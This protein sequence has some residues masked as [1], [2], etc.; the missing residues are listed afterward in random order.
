MTIEVTQEN[1]IKRLG[2]G[3][4][5]I[6]TDA[7]VEAYYG[8]RFPGMD[9]F[10]IAPGE[11][12]KS[13]ETYER[14][15]AYMQEK[16]MTRGDY[17]IALGGGVVGDL[18]GFAASTYMRG[19]PYINIPTT[20]LAMVD[21]SVGGKTGINMG[22]A[23]NAIGSFYNPTDIWLDVG[24]LETL[25]KRE[26]ASGMAEIIKY[27]IGFDPEMIQQIQAMD[28]PF[29]E[30]KNNREHI[31]ALIIKS[32]AIKEKV[33][34]D[35]FRDSGNRQKLNFGHTLGHAI[36]AYYGFKT[37]THGEAVAI[38]MAYQLKQANQLGRLSDSAYETCMAL[39]N[40]FNLPVD[41]RVPDHICGVAWHVAK[42]KK[43]KAT[44]IH[45]IQL[46]K[47]GQLQ[48]IPVDFTVFIDNL[49]CDLKIKTATVA[50][51]KLSGYI[52]G[53]PS[54]SI[55]HRA[56]IAAGLSET[57]TLVGPLVMSN[58]MMA[59][60]EGMKA[61]GSEIV[62]SK[63]GY[64][65]IHKKSGDV[66]NALI[67]CRES[68]STLRFLMP[69]CFLAKGGVTF[70]GEGR[71]GDRPLTPYYKVFDE[72]EVA[73]TTADGGL[74]V[75]VEGNLKPGLYE[76]PGNISSQFVTGLLMALPLLDG[77]SII[78]LTTP[79]ESKGYVDLTLEVLD[80]YNVKIFQDSELT[81]RIPGNQH[82]EGQ[83]FYVESDYSQAAF[84][85][86]A[87][88]LGSNVKVEGLNEKSRQGDRV[89]D[90][91]L[92]SFACKE[93]TIDL[94]NCPDLLPILSVVAAVT[95]GKTTF[96]GGKRVRLKESDRL[97][98][99]AVELDKMGASIEETPDGLVI[100][101]QLTLK[102]GHVWSWNDHRVAMALAIAAT[103]C[104]TEVVIHG[105]QS[106]DKS[107]PNFWE[108]Y[109]VLGGEVNVQHIG[110]TV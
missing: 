17:L 7:N 45:T 88:A 70:T 81:Y 47:L 34:E 102:G 31:E 89:I 108:H 13:I 107:Y 76:I 6:V 59:T 30:M 54:K 85:I 49:G 36:E 90:T 63:D 96:V 1:L 27:A 42:D 99:M 92:K 2:P 91:V 19:V 18:T 80:H 110:E 11:M 58:D 41:L 71:L 10:V 82:Y 12:S 35:D 3:R 69:F 68:G 46:E 93:R 8:K 16:G 65:R 4:H 56:I 15:I 53:I 97:H 44:H 79:L 26:F 64:Y 48:I 106:V 66:E 28:W 74:P 24:F 103:R 33:V 83:D 95:P 105:S 61:L 100:S 62:L 23:K 43:R 37:Y 39:F 109:R 22:N 78:K 75:T 52:P 32:I 101:G 38:G 67:Q 98:A 57:P 40:K 60:L 87:N 21:S 86:G 20:L 29:D 14:L 5:L 50:P 72:M 51:R 9:R 84:W 94:S 25:P 104:E 55:A 73:Y 77:T